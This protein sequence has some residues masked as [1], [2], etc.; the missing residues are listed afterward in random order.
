VT[1]ITKPEP[2][3]LKRALA[4]RKVTNRE[5]AQRIDAN[6]NQV[7]RY[8]NGLRPGFTTRAKIAAALEMDEA[9]LW[10]Q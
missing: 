7:S 4:D 3:P 6:E 10:P 2:T 1:E 5:L 8:A 9:A